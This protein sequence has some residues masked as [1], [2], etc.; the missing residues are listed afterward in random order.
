MHA[1]E[2]LWAAG[3]DCFDLDILVTADSVLMVGH[4]EW[5]QSR[6]SPPAPADAARQTERYTRE[7]F[8]L[9]GATEELFPRLESVMEVFSRL[10]RESGMTYSAHHYMPDLG[11][12]PVLLLDFKGAAFLD[13]PVQKGV[14]AAVKAGVVQHTMVWVPDSHPAS[15]ESVDSSAR[16][17][18]NGPASFQWPL[19]PCPATDT[20]AVAIRPM[21]CPLK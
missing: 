6:L 4:P 18:A 20:C 19:P 2:R 14:A 12:E 1:V 8:A 17:T 10:L 21:Q 5:L 11:R 9:W 16:V 13:G 3:I 7:Q 15:G